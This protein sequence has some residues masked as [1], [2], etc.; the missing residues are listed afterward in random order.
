MTPF[1]LRFEWEDA[2][3]VRVPIDR[4]VTRGGGR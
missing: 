3:G 1:V 4:A 2:P